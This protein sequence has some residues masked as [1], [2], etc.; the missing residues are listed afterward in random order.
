MAA[1]RA[2]SRPSPARGARSSRCTGRPDSRVVTLTRPSHQRGPRCFLDTSSA[3]WLQYFLPLGR[4]LFCHPLNRSPLID[5]LINL[6]GRRDVYRCFVLVALAAVVAASPLSAASRRDPAAMVQREE[7][8][9]VVFRVNVPDARLT[10]SHALSGAERLTIDGY[11]RTGTPG[12]PPTL[13]CVFFVG[14]PPE[15]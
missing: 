6:T 3:R 2:T 4:R 13:F 7:A 1:A 15:G 5:T 8:G 10:P 12:A 14:L 11:Q 9:R